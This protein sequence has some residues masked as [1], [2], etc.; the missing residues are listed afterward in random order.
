VPQDFV[1]DAV[2]VG[3]VLFRA[4]LRIDVAAVVRELEVERQVVDAGAAILERVDAEVGRE[5][6]GGALH[7]LAEADGADR[8]GPCDGPAGHRHRVHVLEQHRVGADV[9]HVAAH[10]EQQGNRA[11]AAHDPADPER[12][13][14]RLAQA[15][16]L[17]HVEVDDGGRFVAADLEHR[18]DVVGAV[19][20]YSA[21]ERRLDRDAAIRRHALGCAQPVGFDVHQRDRQA[22]GQFGKAR[23][24]ADQRAR[25]DRRARTD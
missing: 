6:T 7:R 9:L 21:I 17:R 19:E 1:A 13:A 18:Q 4:K 25:E 22:L 23:D 3:D 24:V 8:A 14:D 12:V 16:A 20:C 2:R 10:V 11:Q 5:V 15:E